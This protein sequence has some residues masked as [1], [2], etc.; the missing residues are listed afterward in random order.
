MWGGTV[1]APLYYLILLPVSQEFVLCGLSYLCDE[2]S[3]RS[4]KSYA[5]NRRKIKRITIDIAG[6]K[7]QN[8]M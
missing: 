3:I 4:Q 5:V 8:N 7:D 1:L 6:R 2:I